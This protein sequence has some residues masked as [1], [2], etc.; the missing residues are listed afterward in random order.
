MDKNQ[1]IDAY[2]CPYMHFATNFIVELFEDN[3]TWSVRHT[4]NDRYYDLC[5]GNFT[6]KENFKCSYESYVAHLKDSIGDYNS[7]CFP[8]SSDGNTKAMLV[9]IFGVVSV[10]LIGFIVYTVTII[11]KLKAEYPTTKNETYIAS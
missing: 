9:W 11:K 5:N 6:D 8:N 2:L 4:Y 10:V 3:G 1:T 7:F